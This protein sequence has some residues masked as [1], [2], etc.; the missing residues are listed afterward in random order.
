MGMCMHSVL[1]DLSG[2]L[3]MC[4]TAEDTEISSQDLA[5]SVPTPNK[6]SYGSCIICDIQSSDFISHP[7]KQGT[8]SKLP[9]Q[10]T[11]ESHILSRK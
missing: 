11:F 10:I 7:C 9:S 5:N 2:V 8:T 4:C 6:Q 3:Q 1:M